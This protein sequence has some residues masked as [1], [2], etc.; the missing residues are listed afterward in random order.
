MSIFELIITLVGLFISMID[1]FIQFYK[2][3]IQIRLIPAVLLLILISSILITRGIE[4]RELSKIKGTIR[5]FLTDDKFFTKLKSEIEIEEHLMY[6]QYNKD[7][8]N[9]AF[10]EMLRNNELIVEIKEVANTELKRN[11]N[12]KFFFLS[13]KFVENNYLIPTRQLTKK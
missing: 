4:R 13:R 3:E 6:L 5:N 12:L 8:C 7:S 9:K 11:Y 1:N 10:T 2:K